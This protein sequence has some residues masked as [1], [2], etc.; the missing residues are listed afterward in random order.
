VS[1]REDGSNRP[2]GHCT[3]AISNVVL[4]VA[5]LFLSAASSAAFAQNRKVRIVATNG[6]PIAYA[7]VSV[8]GGIPHISDE[9][10][11]ISLGAGKKQTLSVSIRRIGYQPWFGNV[12]VPDTAAV[13]KL[14]LQLLPQTLAIV[15]VA[16]E[17]PI[18]SPLKLKG[19]YDRALMREKGLL[20]A[21]FIGPEELEFRHPSMIAD[22][23]RGLNGISVKDKDVA[24]GYN[25]QCPVAI[26]LDGIRLCPPGGCHMNGGG[27]IPQIMGG[28]QQP[29]QV[30]LSQIEAGA[31]SAIEVYNRG[32]N[33]PVSLQVS[34]PGC[35]VIAIWTGSR[36][37]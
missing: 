19:F 8:Q 2:R 13:L 14:T 34:D 4:A 37:P 5:L 10:G 35:G 21:V 25:G 29:D 36:R 33:M 24:Y 31:V 9:N 17:A 16:G 3:A 32:G 15:T 7:T 28:G 18:A 6:Q 12:E 26:L 23:L 27:N 11:E 30:H 20:S 1:S 22:M